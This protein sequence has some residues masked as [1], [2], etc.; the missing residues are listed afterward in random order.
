MLCSVALLFLTGSLRLSQ[1]LRGTTKQLEENWALGAI[2]Y[3]LY[4][5]AQSGKP[6]YIDLVHLGN[7]TSAD[8]GHL[9]F[10]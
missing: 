6:I 4:R 8:Y 1:F 5:G 7:Q 9:W 10:W 2:A 3:P